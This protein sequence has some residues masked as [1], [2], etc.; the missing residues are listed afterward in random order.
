V[1]YRRKVSMGVA[2]PPLIDQSV[3]EWEWLSVSGDAAHS[4]SWE[5]SHPCTTESNQDPVILY[6]G[7]RYHE[8]SSSEVS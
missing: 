7:D 1:K 3:T 2:G 8:T 4:F 5:L 6:E